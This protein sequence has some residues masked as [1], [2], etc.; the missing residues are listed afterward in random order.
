MVRPGMRGGRVS[1]KPIGTTA[2]P[3]SADQ[4]GKGRR[5]TNGVASAPSANAAVAR[6]ARPRAIERVRGTF[7]RLPADALRTA[8]TQ[9]A[10]HALVGQAGYAAVDTP[11]LEHTELFLRKSGGDRLAQLYAFTHHG[12]NVALRPEFTAS[13]VRQF[14]EAWQGEPLPVRVAYTG[15][16]FRYEKPQAGRARQFTEFGCELIGAT[17]VAADV[18]VISLA[19]DALEQVGIERPRLVLGHIGIVAGF[20]AGLHVDQRA[21]DWLTWSMERT[22]KRASSQRGNPE[23]VGV[24]VPGELD[25][26]DDD[27]PP[28]LR[29]LEAAL[30][31]DDVD[32]LSETADPDAVASILRQTGVA[33]QGGSRTPEEI[34]RGLFAKRDRRYDAQTLRDAAAFVERLTELAG[35]PDE[36]LGSIRELVRSRALDESPIDA[37]EQT[38][39]LLRATR[40]SEFDIHIDLGMGRGLHYYTGML[41]EIYA[42]GGGLQL[43]G[44]G[45]YDDLA[46]VLGARQPVAAC[47]F[48][49]GLERV[50]AAAPAP[51][52]APAGPARVLVVQDGDNAADAARLATVL[53]VAGWQAVLDLRR[54]NAGATRATAARQGYG[55]IAHGTPTA[56]HLQD[57]ST[58]SE[59]TFDV[60]P[61]PQ[62]VKPHE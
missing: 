29:R 56:V 28:Y 39:N 51:D 20:L 17:G 22:R 46:S 25:A 36:V 13:V 12:R 7:D 32:E 61:T 27:L 58:G 8:E 9:R 14:I 23:G 41:F 26:N 40:D 57:L 11:V 6:A 49:L 4:A 16:V 34:V 44:G 19:L 3:D 52:A 53:R 18:E 15:P 55:W 2:A 45:R 33:F 62:D 31:I 42:A 48:S 1:E 37:I 21:Q 30:D 47:G 5:P 59:Y 50:L 24:D 35:P 60:A 10:L 43:C 38:V 54:R